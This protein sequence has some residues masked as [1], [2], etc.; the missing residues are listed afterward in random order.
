[1]FSILFL[2]FVTLS[3]VVFDQSEGD[4]EGAYI[5]IKKVAYYYTDKDK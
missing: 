3:I 1:M 4:H 2:A 5:L